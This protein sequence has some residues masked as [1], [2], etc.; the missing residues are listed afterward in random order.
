[1]GTQETTDTRRNGTSDISWGS[2]IAAV[3][4]FLVALGALIG[5]D[6]FMRFGFGI[7]AAGTGVVLLGVWLWFGRR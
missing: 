5:A 7:V 1:M 3:G 2:L 4:M 6:A